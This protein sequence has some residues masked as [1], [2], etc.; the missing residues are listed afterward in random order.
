MAK[1][2]QLINRESQLRAV[3]DG[4]EQAIQKPNW[5]AEA[6]QKDGIQN[7][8]DAKLSKHAEWKSKIYFTE[9]TSS[10]PPVVVIEDEGTKGLTGRVP[11]DKD[12]LVR[13]L[14]SEDPDERV[15]YFIS[16]DWSKKESGSLGSRG[17]GKMIFIG[18]SEKSIMFF[19]SK[20]YDDG[21]Y[22]F[23]L[24]YLDQNKEIQVE[25]YEGNIAER[26]RKSYLG[27]TIKNLEGSGTRIF[28]P[29]PKLELKKAVISGDL[30]TIIQETWW[31][32][33][34]KY[35][36]SIYVGR[37]D[38]LTKVVPSSFLPIEKSGIKLYEVYPNIHIDQGL[39]I[40]RI[41][42]GYLG[43]KEIPYSYQGIA[44]QRGGMT[45][46][47]R[48][49][50]YFTTEISPNSI[51]GSVEFEPDLDNEMLKLESPEH[52]TFTW[53][54][55]CA[56][57]VNRMIKEKVLEFAK[58]HHLLDDQTYTPKEQREAEI[59]A[60]KDLNKLARDLGLT[61]HGW[62]KRK[63][64]KRK[65]PTQEDPIILS[66]PDFETPYE[67]GRV[68]KGQALE[69]CYTAPLSSFK[70]PLKVLIRIWVFR[71]EGSII[72]ELLQEKEVFVSSSQKNIKIGWDSIEIND[73]FMKGKYNLKAKII[74]LEYKTLDGQKRVEKGDILYREVSKAFW[75]DEDPPD[76]GFFEIRR[77][78]KDQKN[79]YM[80]WEEDSGSYL[81]YWNGN[82]P[83]LKTISEDKVFFQDLLHREGVYFLWAIMVAEIQSEAN[84]YSGKIK[85]EVL[86]LEK[87]PF[88]TQF[89][90]ILEKRS[91]LLWK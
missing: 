83:A 88:E 14:K 71:D 52:Y 9:K 15:A 45:I 89:R 36:A 65:Q 46:E 53:Y 39:K 59:A 44:I 26:K 56:S 49:L 22:V 54:K 47:R 13:I 48:S 19:D 87:Q 6:V 62:T 20:R 66:I 81:L 51:Y 1:F 61:G 35:N 86:E 33:L 18:S 2:T 79:K 77:N 75:V 27:K 7:S 17:R 55:G 34:S 32:I 84:E 74:S 25:V 67:N 43:N 91:E 5:L 60:Q 42:L 12:D 16:S 57:R 10:S 90:W 40:K 58:K 69:G 21:K 68:D 73:R 38:L 29:Y 63:K 82:H 11:K 64:K 80:W 70:D 31:E 50:S 28:I 72:S 30:V 23:G 8:W 3:L 41:T 76:H 78:D 37:Q 85:K 24:T 4:Y